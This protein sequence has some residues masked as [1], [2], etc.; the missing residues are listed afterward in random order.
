MGAAARGNL[1][2]TAKLKIVTPAIVATI[3]LATVWAIAAF[4]QQPPAA[5][6]L[7]IVALLGAGA[8][9]VTAWFAANNIG[10]LQQD[11][12]R[13]TSDIAANRYQ[14]SSK[15]TDPLTRALD[16]LQ[17]AFKNTAEQYSRQTDAQRQL[18]EEIARTIDDALGNLRSQKDAS[19]DAAAAVE[20]MSASITNTYIT[21][22]ESVGANQTSTGLATSGVDIIKNASERMIKIGVSVKQSA[23][24][25]E[26]VGE[27]SGRISAVVRVI[28]EVADQTNLL[29]LNAAIEAAR[30]GDS[31]RGFAVVADEVR[32]LAEKTTAS[33]TEINAMV[34][35]IQGT[36]ATAVE[37]IRIAVAQVDETT[38]LAE[39]ARESI[40]GIKV[41]AGYSED[42]ARQ[43]S[44]A[45]GEQSTAI[46]VTAQ[47]VETIANV[48]QESIQHL[49]RAS[50]LAGGFR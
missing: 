11:H 4:A 13:I 2:M 45:L 47:K 19:T 28:R 41:S 40:D 50:E 27:Q 16:N 44:E 42:Y 12:I 48:L 1:D 8:S 39:S 9:L 37:N 22:A 30:A 33:A 38:S 31:G 46:S 34:K 10:R 15:Y 26:H 35:E 32:K 23:T 36:A 14:S 20:Q 25:I 29:A 3:A 49:A 21:A 18:C 24:V 7:A 5:A 6:I 43:I 17:Q